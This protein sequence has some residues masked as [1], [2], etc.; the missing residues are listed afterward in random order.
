MHG[1]YKSKLV[2]EY[3]HTQ[4]YGNGQFNLGLLSPGPLR[5]CRS[6]FPWMIEFFW[7]IM[8]RHTGAGINSDHSGCEYTRVEQAMVCCFFPSHLIKTALKTTICSLHTPN[9]LIRE[10]HQHNQYDSQICAPTPLPH[11]KNWNWLWV[12]CQVQVRWS[13]SEI[14]FL[15]GAPEAKTILITYMHTHMYVM[16]MSKNHF[17]ISQKIY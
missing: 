15:N 17:S 1:S 3:N 2:N 7:C 10:G 13:E 9:Y 4:R 11:K 16:I 6:Y 12:W 14:L 8:G 5:V